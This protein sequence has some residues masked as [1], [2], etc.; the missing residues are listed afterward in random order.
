[1]V[2]ADSYDV[3]VLGSGIAGLA[4]VLAASEQGLRPLLIEKS[5]KLGGGTTNSYGLI[6][7]GDNHLAR[8]A[9]YEDNRADVVRYMRFLAGGEE[10]DANLLAFVDWSPRALQ[11]F[12]SCGV[13]FR[14]THGITDHYYGVAPGAQGEGR[15]VEAELISGYDL[16]AW[17]DR[18]RVPVG[19]PFFVTAEE[20][21]AWGGINRFS[22]WDQTLVR[23]RRERD[24]RG[25]GVGLICRFLKAILA[26]AV[27]ILMGEGIERLTLEGDRVS[28]V[29]L[30]GGRQITARRGVV[31]A[32]GGYESNP[33]LVRDFE[34]LPNWLSLYPASIM[35]D[36]LM[37]ATEIGAA[38]RTIRN[39]L[40]LFL[41]FPLP[42]DASGEEAQTHLAGIIELC[43]PHTIVVNQAGKR[44]ADESYFQGM[45]PALRHF[46]PATHCYSNLPCYL[47]FDQ[48]YAAAYSFAGRHA[49]AEIPG[50]VSQAE[51]PRALGAKLG[52]N[53]DGLAATIRRF[54]DFCH[55]GADKDFRRGEL[56]WR[57]ARDKGLPSGQNPSL[58]PLDKPP[59]YGIELIPAGGSSAGVL[60][61]ENAQVL[62]RRGQPLPGLYATGN[63][64]A[65]VEFGAGYQA[66][67]TLASGMTFAYLAVD[68]MLKALK[69]ISRDIYI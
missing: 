1:M 48:N 46:D 37:L 13:S 14:L 34:G 3:I 7:I 21:I 60:T 68:H 50:W 23:E 4:T 30:R 25:K 10:R 56:A 49:G 27:P 29:E 54:N 31:L 38:V 62:H 5:E 66:G 20:Q 67:L 53:A 11:F 47:I 39:N 69:P 41:A 40:Q 15:T 9:G 65:K 12:E 51:D 58:G 59:F 64:A 44:F 43:S 32:T 8:A 55:T 26:R 63:T 28:G 42:P 6:W 36:G 18:V 2:A 22:S 16:G 52:V 24:I 35:G 17:R 33:D 45:V 61:N 57:L 19:T